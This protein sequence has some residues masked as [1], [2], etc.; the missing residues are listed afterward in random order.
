[1][2]TSL[3]PRS[4]TC[5]N[6]CAASTRTLLSAS[7]N[8]A[9]AALEARGSG[10][11]AMRGRVRT[12]S[13]RNCARPKESLPATIKDAKVPTASVSPR[14]QRRLNTARAAS[15]T[16]SSLSCK[17]MLQAATPNMPPSTSA[18]PINSN[19]AQRT[20]TSWCSTANFAK[21]DIKA[22]LS[23]L[24]RT[25]S[26]R[27]VL[28]AT[29]RTPASLSS[30]AANAVRT[31][32]GSF[33]SASTRKVSVA[34]CLTSESEVG[35]SRT[36]LTVMVSISSP[37]GQTSRK[38]RS[39]A[40]RT[41]LLLSSKHCPRRS[42]RTSWKPNHVL[43]N[44]GTKARNASKAA[45]RTSGDCFALFVFPGPLPRNTAMAG[46]FVASPCLDARRMASMISSSDTSPSRRAWPRLRKSMSS[47][48]ANTEHPPPPSASSRCAMS[49]QTPLAT[50][51]RHNGQSWQAWRADAMHKVWNLCPQPGTLKMV[52]GPPDRPLRQTAHASGSMFS[53]WLP[54]RAWFVSAPWP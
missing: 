7:A 32:R 10:R 21:S 48:S 40:M 51:P 41:S 14:F 3:S 2:E 53:I 43:E 29:L 47:S 11:M 42:V 34:S 49:V 9:R 28:R 23:A 50:S 45:T 54:R 22:L 24:P 52:A 5:F 20:S 8:A 18:C 46:I 33:F 26:E 44:A 16:S 4:Q 13:H 27:I 31:L 36:R 25:Q 15:C 35:S 17:A 39:A 37:L 1:M 38:A 12:A 30:K 19:A 6:V